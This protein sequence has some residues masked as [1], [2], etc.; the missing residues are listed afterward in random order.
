MGSDSFVM[1]KIFI[2]QAYTVIS[3]DTNVRVLETVFNLDEIMFSGIL[4]EVI[5]GC[6]WYMT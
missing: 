5:A 3:K 4:S 1:I 6:G 2:L